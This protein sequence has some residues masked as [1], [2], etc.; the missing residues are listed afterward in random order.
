M[1]IKKK[2]IKISATCSTNADC[3]SSPSKPVCK[4]LIPGGSRACSP[5]AS[6]GKECLPV[7]FLAEDSCKSVVELPGNRKWLK[8]D[9]SVFKAN[10][11]FSEIS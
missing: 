11:N 2:V 4:E 8:E 9:H 5:K 7:Q 6:S 3:E 1:F 10:V